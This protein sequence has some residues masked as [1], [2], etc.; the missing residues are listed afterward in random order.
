MQ[1]Q[2]MGLT[3]ASHMLQCARNYGCEKRFLRCIGCV[4]DA[5][6]QNG[7]EKEARQKECVLDGMQR[8]QLTR[9]GVPQN[10]CDREPPYSLVLLLQG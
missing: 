4:G 6:D 5:L 3:Y 1:A 8:R 2:L 7:M 9:G 10:T